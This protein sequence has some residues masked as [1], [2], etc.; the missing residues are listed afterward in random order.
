MLGITFTGDTSSLPS[1]LPI[2]IYEYG[3]NYSTANTV[4]FTATDNWIKTVNLK[5]STNYNCD[6]RVS[7]YYL[8]N[9]YFTTPSAANSS[10][11]N[12]TVFC[13]PRPPIP[14]D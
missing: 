1:S 9:S 14:D 5:A 12:L 13:P 10:P 7:D 2:Q 8:Q 6:Y 11:I 3:T 4:T